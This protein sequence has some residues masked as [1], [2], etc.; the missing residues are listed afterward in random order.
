VGRATLLVYEPFNYPSGTTSGTGVLLNGQSGGTGM[1]GSW[2]TVNTGTA[3]SVTN[4]LQPNLSGVNLNTGVANTFNGTVANLPT[5]GGYFG[6]IGLGGTAN[7]TDHIYAYRTLDPSVTATFTAGST[8]WFSFVSARAFNANATGP[9]LAIG[10]GRLSTSDR[11]Q[12]ALGEAIGAGGGLGTNAGSNTSKVYGQFWDQAVAGTG[13]FQTYD[14]TGSN[15]LNNSSTTPLNTDP[16]ISP[17]QAFTWASDSGTGQPIANIVIGKIQWNDG[18]PDVLTVARFL[19]T[20]GTL[21]EALFNSSALPS[22]TTWAVQ[23][24]L[25][26]SKFNTISI[27]GGRYFADEFRIA[28]TFDEVV[29]VS[30]V[31]E[32]SL[33]AVLGA[34]LAGLTAAVGLQRRRRFRLE[35]RSSRG[36]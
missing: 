27:A 17:W 2:A 15:P 7:T 29:G 12:T 9:K 22:S 10:A 30:I 24:D 34:G 6:S 14:A 13:T 26:Q 32:P 4:Y 31:P 23:P 25:D 19:P 11:G 20:S 21:T 28:T 36:R 8:T 5:S 16:A 3:N 18:T 1:T 35:E 33:L